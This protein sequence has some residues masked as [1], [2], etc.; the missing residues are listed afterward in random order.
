MSK[1]VDGIE[2]AKLC[3]YLA[4]V[5]GLIVGIGCGFALGLGAA[6][7]CLSGCFISPDWDQGALSWDEWFFIK[8]VPILGG[9]WVGWT[10]LYSRLVPRH[11]H[12]LSHLPGL[13][14][15]TRIGWIAILYAGVT[16]ALWLLAGVSI[17]VPIPF[18]AAWGAGLFIADLGHWARDGFPVVI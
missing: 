8:R 10:T 9:F 18:I 17:N 7:G 2:H 16:Y 3:L 4:P 14:T 11:R 5:A 15:L 1:N 13:G 6:L 12:I